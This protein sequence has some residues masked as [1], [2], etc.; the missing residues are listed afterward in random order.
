MPAKE[1]F[2]RILKTCFQFTLNFIFY[3]CC[4]SMFSV[5]N[6]VSRDFHLCYLS[7]TYL[8]I[9]HKL[10]FNSDLSYL[11]WY[12]EFLKRLSEYVTCFDICLLA[13][14]LISV[15]ECELIVYK[16]RLWKDKWVIHRLTRLT[17]NDSEWQQV[18]QRMIT[19]DNER[20]RVVQQV[21][22]SDDEWQRMR[23]SGLFS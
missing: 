9:K 19:S 8:F 21:T 4:H 15:T 23:T 6:F 16:D 2:P 3:F 17:T 5:K 12:L 22:T 18:V 10:M 1:L 7:I 14:M 11:Y 20:Q 13:L